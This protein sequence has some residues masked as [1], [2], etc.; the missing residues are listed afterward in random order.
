MKVAV[1]FAMFDDADA[2]MTGLAAGVTPRGQTDRL[3]TT[4]ESMQSIAINLLA[5][6]THL[7]GHVPNLL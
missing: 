4:L 7:A 1:N 2:R 5:S 3:P 6:R